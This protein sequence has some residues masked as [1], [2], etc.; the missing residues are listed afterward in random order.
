VLVHVIAVGMVEVALVQIIDV[1]A[2]LDR[3]V[4]AAGVVGVIVVLVCS[5]I[6]HGPSVGHGVPEHKQ[7]RTRSNLRL[8]AQIWRRGRIL[9]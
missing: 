3:G 7:M 4:S 6:V 1:I 2:V 8:P 9:V 5:V